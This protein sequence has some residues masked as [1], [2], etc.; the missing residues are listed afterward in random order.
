MSELLQIESEVD[1]GKLDIITVFN[2]HVKGVE[3]CLEGQNIN[4][5]GKEGHWLEKKMGIKHNAK[6]E[7]D[8]NGYEMKTGDKATTFIDKAPNYMY[9]DG[10]HMPKRDKSLKTRYWDKYASKKETD[11]PTIGGWSVDKF[12]KSGQK[13]VVDE[14]NNVTVLYDYEHDT[15]ENK[16]LLEINTIP[17]IIMRWDANALSSA[18]E[19]K[20]NKKGFFKCMKENNRFS[21]ICFGKKITFDTWINELKKGVIYHDGY[22][23]VGGRGR[24]MFRASNKFWNNL[25]TEEY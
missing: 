12:N 2:T 15:R 25:I 7:P 5:S 16:E 24:H 21:K 13:M 22:S 3:I 14:Y 1:S 4:H 17:H 23:K 6:N 10:D 8:I 9:L 19:N 20:F 11:I 18:I